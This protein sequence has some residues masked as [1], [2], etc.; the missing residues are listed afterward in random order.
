VINKTEL[1][2]E[3]LLKYNAY[4]SEKWIKAYFDEF[5]GGFNI[6]HKEHNFSNIGCKYK[7]IVGKTVVRRIYKNI[8]TI[9]T[10]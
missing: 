10:K 4:D 3:S 2:K 6:Y 8:L 9:Q 5:S 1:L 7:K